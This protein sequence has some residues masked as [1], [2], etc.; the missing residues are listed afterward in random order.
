M[1]NNVYKIKENGKKVRE[2]CASYDET[3]SAFYTMQLWWCYLNQCSFY[4]KRNLAKAKE[5]IST[6]EHTATF[7]RD[8]IV[9]A[10]TSVDKSVKDGVNESKLEF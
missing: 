8:G 4:D 1:A 7:E 9:Y 5:Q 6:N 2:L 10:C 3:F